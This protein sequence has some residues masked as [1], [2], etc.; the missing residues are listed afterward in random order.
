MS[1][2]SD[3]DV[4]RDKMDG[5]ARATLGDIVV[6]ESPRTVDEAVVYDLLEKVW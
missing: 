3:F 1:D 6:R 4:P 2:V 5:V